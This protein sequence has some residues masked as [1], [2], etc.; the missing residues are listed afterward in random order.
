MGWGAS[1]EASAGESNLFGFLLQLS[2]CPPLRLFSF[3]FLFQNHGQPPN[4][5]LEPFKRRNVV[6]REFFLNHSL[7]LTTTDA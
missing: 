6:F 4:K 5:A 2:I 7:L 1:K 3:D